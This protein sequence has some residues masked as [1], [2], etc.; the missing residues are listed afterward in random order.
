MQCKPTQNILYLAFVFPVNQKAFSNDQMGTWWLH[1]FLFVSYR[2]R[3]V[4]GWLCLVLNRQ[5]WKQNDHKEHLAALWSARDAVFMTRFQCWRNKRPH[6]FTLLPWESGQQAKFILQGHTLQKLC[7]AT[8]N[9]T[10]SRWDFKERNETK[11]CSYEQPTL[12]AVR[13][14]LYETSTA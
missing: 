8:P 14:I 9:S 10:S 7:K 4:C 6:L 1:T 3:Q 11:S 2:N 5:T 13:K 12:V